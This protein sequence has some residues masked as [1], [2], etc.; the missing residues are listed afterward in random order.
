M[1]LHKTIGDSRRDLTLIAGEN[2]AAPD[3]RGRSDLD[4][5]ER[6]LESDASRSQAWRRYVVQ[7]LRWWP[8]E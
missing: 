8:D 1:V 7:L 4:I 2:L 3:A 6:D 5:C